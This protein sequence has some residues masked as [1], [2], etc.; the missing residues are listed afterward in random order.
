[1]E[2]FDSLFD[3]ETLVRRP[4]TTVAA[5]LTYHLG[6]RNTYGSMLATLVVSDRQ[7]AEVARD[8]PAG[9]R[10]PVSVITSGGAGGLLGLARRDL[11]SIDMVSAEPALRDFDDLAGSAA[12]V[13]SAAAELGRDIAIFV[14]LPYAPGWDAAV[15]LVEAAGLYGKIAAGEAPSRQTAEQL[16]IL[17]EADLPF[18]ITSRSA[19]GW[20]PLLTAVDALIDGANLDDAATLIQSGDNDQVRTNMSAW[21]QTTLSR[22]RRRIRRL[23]TDQVADVINACVAVDQPRGS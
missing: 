16:S 2:L 13:V 20:L 18:K 6:L 10:V 8:L 7:L 3:D 22:I 5:A 1:M 4:Q 11:P 14:E 19:G 9:V 23:G 21:E 17:I 15:E 12:R